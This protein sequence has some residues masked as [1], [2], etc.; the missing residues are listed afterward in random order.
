M[1]KAVKRVVAESEEFLFGAQ[2]PL[3][4]DAAP[5]PPPPPPAPVYTPPPPAPIAPAP[6]P[7]PPTAV[8]P[9]SAPPGP[10]P[11][12]RALDAASEKQRKRRG[13]SSTIATNPLGLS[14]DTLTTA[15]SDKTL[16]G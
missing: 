14:D 13:R 5:S 15:A 2:R 12:Q 1:A 11:D 8:T 10:T 6:P 3:T 16:L 9:P 7:P 4:G